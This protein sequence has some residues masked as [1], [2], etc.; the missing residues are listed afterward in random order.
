MRTLAID[1]CLMR[2]FPGPKSRIR[3]EPPVHTKL[4]AKYGQR[5][6]GYDKCWLFPRIFYVFGPSY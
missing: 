6:F 3:Q 4:L 1:T 5:N 2:I